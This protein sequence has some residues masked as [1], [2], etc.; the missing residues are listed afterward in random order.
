MTP[1]SGTSGTSVSISGISGTYFYDK[2]LVMLIKDGS[3]PIFSSTNFTFSS[4]DLIASGA[5]DLRGVPPGV[6]DL[7]VVDFYGNIGKLDNAFT[8]N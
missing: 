6:Y 2:P 8:V 1:T 5:F 3:N 4:Q 7:Q